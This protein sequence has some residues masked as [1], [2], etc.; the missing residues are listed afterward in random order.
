MKP[1]TI[2]LTGLLI[3]LVLF[4]AACGSSN[5]QTTNGLSKDTAGNFGNLAINGQE[6]L[7]GMMPGGKG[8]P[9]LALSSGTRLPKQLAHLIPE[10]GLSALSTEED[11]CITFAGDFADTD[12]DEI[13]V[14]ATFTFDCAYSEEGSDFTVKGS[15]NFQDANDDDAVSGYAIEF[16]DFTITE[17]KDGKTNGLEL[18]QKF[19]LA[20]DENKSLYV[21]E[22]DLELNATT[23]EGSFTYS[24][25]AT[26]GYAPDDVA[27]PFA[28]G[29][30]ALNGVT[31][32]QS[33]KDIYR[34]TEVSPAL[35]YS[36]SC[37]SGFDAGTVG[38]ED[39][40]DN[41][42]L[43]IYEACD[44]VTVIYN[45]STLEWK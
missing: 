18:D 16:L 17:T 27:D 41:N 32:W 10:R 35:H 5:P 29:T 33:G 12:T 15:A 40:F 3:L 45:G 1:S 19:I 11:E 13:P 24:E 34:L 25:L 38:F 6:R 28:A 43:I 21:I 37:E 42:M 4:L 9:S 44:K 39:N 20:I 14:N 7:L 8:V 36:A 30:F 22:N 31:T 26:L 23:P 2:F